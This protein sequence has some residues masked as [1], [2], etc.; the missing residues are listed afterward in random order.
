M[1]LKIY[2]VAPLYD[3]VVLQ[4]VTNISGEQREAAGSP[5]MS[6]ITEQLT[7]SVTMQKAIFF[8]FFT[9]QG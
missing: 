6:I 4:V 9:W 1:A 3:C 7:H 8:F 2:I 5:E